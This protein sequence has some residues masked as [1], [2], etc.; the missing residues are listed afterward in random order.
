MAWDLADLVPL[1]VTIKDASGTPADAG[2]VILTIGLPDGTSTTPTVVH[3]GTGIYKVDYTPTMAGRHT[4]AWVATGINASGSTDAFDVLPAVPGYVV[5]LTDIKTQ[6]NIPAGTT[7]NDEE[8]RGFLGSATSV[9]ERVRSEAVVRQTITEQHEVRTGRLVLNKTPVV[10]L[11]SV[12]TTDGW[13][14]W[15]PAGLLISPSG[16]VM[17]KTMSGLLELAGFITVTYVAGYMVIPDEFQLAAKIIVQ[18]LWQTQRGDRGGPRPGAMEDVTTVP[19]IA[20]AVPNRALELLGPG[21]RG[22]A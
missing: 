19:G 14:S 10:S 1:T 20:F 12:A 3:G 18:H 11:T 15:D 17:A 16:V 8:L 4:V 7:T 9:V 22:L 5:S 21:T 6:L 13:I 2:N